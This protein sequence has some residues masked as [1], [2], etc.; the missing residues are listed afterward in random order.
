MTA[1]FVGVG[2]VRVGIT[3][4]PDGWHPARVNVHPCLQLPAAQACGNRLSAQIDDS[5]IV[6]EAENGARGVAVPLS[7]RAIQAGLWLMGTSEGSSRFHSRLRCLCLTVKAG[8]FADTLAAASRPE[9]PLPLDTRAADCKLHVSERRAKSIHECSLDRNIDLIGF[10][11]LARGFRRKL[12]GWF[13][14][15]RF[16]LW[17]LH[18]DNPCLS[19]MI[20]DFVTLLIISSQSRRQ[21]TKGRAAA[22]CLVGHSE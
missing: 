7:S 2:N 11:F 13:W 9:Q 6:V 15:Y 12:V 4:Q 17:R 16:W 19:K 20:P 22:P 10:I 3:F 21:K 14:R 8:E 5:C 18:A 1:P